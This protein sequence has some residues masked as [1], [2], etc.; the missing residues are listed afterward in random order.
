MTV[1][2]FESRIYSRCGCFRLSC[3]RCRFLFREPS[4][5]LS[6]CHPHL[7]VRGMVPEINSAYPLEN[8]LF[9]TSV[10]RQKAKPNEF[11]SLL[12]VH[13]GP[14]S[15]A[16]RGSALLLLREKPCRSE[17]S[18]PEASIPLMG[19]RSTPRMG[20]ASHRQPPTSFD[21]ATVVP[22]EAGIIISA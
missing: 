12:S 6:C 14:G 5:V 18:V 1:L 10:Q 15:L 11:C 21:P 8:F 22:N 13:R 20:A 19:P 3:R 16:D 4:G 2:S 9:I 7:S 17:G